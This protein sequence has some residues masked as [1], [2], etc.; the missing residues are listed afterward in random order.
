M[1]SFVIAGDEMGGGACFLY[2]EKTDMYT[3]FCNEQKQFSTSHHF[4]FW[5]E[6]FYCKKHYYYAGH[7]H[8]YCRAF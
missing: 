4:N 5:T 7:S 8:L 3:Y 2:K 1:Y 6:F